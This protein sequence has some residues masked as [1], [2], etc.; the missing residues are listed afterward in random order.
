MKKLFLLKWLVAPLGLTSIA[1]FV[2]S[3][4]VDEP[5]R[6]L[7]INLTAGLLGSIITVFFVERVIRWKEKEEWAKVLGHVGKQ[8]NI[9][10]N[11]TCSSVRLGLR[12][13][14]PRQDNEFEVAHDP[15]LM[16]EMMINLIEND[17]LP[18]MSQLAE[19]DQKAWKT[20][21]MN[22]QGSVA[23]AER[24]M[25]LFS[26]NLDPMI[27]ELVLD[28][29]EEARG[30]LGHYMTWP[31]LLGVPLDQLEPN[32]R[33]ESSVPLMRAT[34]KLIVAEAEQLLKTCAQLLREIDKHFPD[35]KP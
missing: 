11:G 14:L 15:H 21:A 22:M 2:L 10:A 9:L 3:F 25:T 13:P 12:L 8:V 16:R 23:D 6:G 7:L 33:G 19:M 34:Y 1:L 5:W 35:R 20:F 30:L 26:R 24:I 28:I 27:M 4:W 31:D 18:R 29:H 17:L 32:K